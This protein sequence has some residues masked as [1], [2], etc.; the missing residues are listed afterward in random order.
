MAGETVREINLNRQSHFLTVSSYK[1]NIRLDGII[2]L[3]RI[4]DNRVS[5]STLQ[6][7]RMFTKVCGDDA[8]KNV[9]LATTMWTKVER[10]VG[11]RREKELKER[12]WA[13]LL[14]SGARAMPFGDSFQS[15]WQIIDQI[16]DPEGV[17]RKCQALL[18]QEEL[19]IHGRPLNETEA[20][21]VLCS[22][23]QQLLTE[24]RETLRQ[25]RDE[26]KAVPN[27]MLAQELGLQC[28]AMQTAIK[29]TCDQLEKMKIPLR[30]RFLM[31][32]SWDK[33]RVVSFRLFIDRMMLND[34]QRCI[35]CQ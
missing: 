1:K 23:L 16:A 5:G 27:Q 4:S 18:L 12:Y 33:P 31:L 6:N 25:L 20:G 3:H 10:D 13:G 17:Q 22:K 30:R 19:V 7:L 8:I 15:S 21:K 9:I 29:S 34:K 35:N 26:A 24:Q 32:L 28:D 2:Y 14:N 11:K